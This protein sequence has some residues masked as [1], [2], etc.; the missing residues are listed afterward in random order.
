MKFDVFFSLCQA[1]V[2]G[3][4]PSERVMFENFFDQVRLAD[5]LGFD[6]AWVAESHLSSEVQKSNPDPVIPHFNGEVGLN[7]DIL[8]LAHKVFG[9]TRRIE[10]GSAIRNILCNGGPLAH[11]ESIRMFLTLHGMNA[12]ESRRLHIGFAAGRFDY[13]NQPY[14]IC[15]RNRSEQVAWQVIKAKIFSEAVEIFCRGL[16]GDIFATNDLAPHKLTPNDFREPT[17]WALFKRAYEEETHTTVADDS[18]TLRP[19]WTFNKVGLIPRESP[20]HLLSL[21]IGSHDPKT[22]ILANSFLACKVFN[23]SITPS[24]MIEETHQRMLQHFNPAGGPWRREYLPRT[25]LV[26]IEGGPQL[27]PQQQSQRARERAQKALESYW[28]AMEG[29]LNPARIAQATENALCGNPE[30]IREQ[31]RTRFHPEDRLMLWFDFN[32]HDNALVK[33]GMRLFAEEVLPYVQEGKKIELPIAST[34]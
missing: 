10:I 24:K 8:Q 17:E 20:L 4:L 28:H 14:G 15:P 23:L 5:A 26:F 32:C 33:R 22:Q 27:T 19:R 6:V 7:T 3:Y 21:T 25:V 2:D 16:K 1:N 31:I 34:R 29:T 11:A 13:S 18:V 9:Q 30:E 12:E